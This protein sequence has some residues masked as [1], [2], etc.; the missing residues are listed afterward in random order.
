MSS[1]HRIVRY[2]NFKDVECNKMKKPKSLNKSKQNNYAFID[3]QNLNLGIKSQGWELDFRE[4]RIYLKNKYNINKAYL[5]IGQI[6][7]ND[8]LYN[9]LSSYGYSLVFKKT[10]LYKKDG[11][12]TVK[13]N[14]D[15]ELVLYAAAK[16]YNNYNNAIIVSGDGDFYCLAEYLTEKNKLLHIFTPNKNY[17]KLLKDY[18][19]KIVR[20]DLLK[21]SL[22]YKKDQHLRSV[23]TLGIS[24]HGDTKNIIAKNRPKSND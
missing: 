7:G 19:S 10:T 12:V 16:V 6:E 18:S 13:G 11:V 2:L 3:S 21:S 4:F 8:N 22:I 14:V 5:F 23:E 15:A 17:S 9:Q 1:S 20:I 24:D